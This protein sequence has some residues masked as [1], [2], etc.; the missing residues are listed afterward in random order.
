VE[1]QTRRGIKQTVSVAKFLSDSSFE[2]AFGSPENRLTLLKLGGNRGF[3][4]RIH[5]PFDGQNLQV[6][7]EKIYGKQPYRAS[8]WASRLVK[9]AQVKYQARVR[10]EFARQ[11]FPGQSEFTDKLREAV[12]S[13]PKLR[14]DHL[15]TKI[16][17]STPKDVTGDQMFAMACAE[18]FIKENPQWTMADLAEFNRAIMGNNI[19]SNKLDPASAKDHPYTGGYEGMRTTTLYL[20]T[21]KTADIL[22]S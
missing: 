14:T 21:G 15:F 5:N 3:S 6:A 16:T 1:V 17:R 19:I 9:G 22:E 13:D 12:I 20:P 8:R 4:S 2:K 11:T 18:S 10:E 7:C